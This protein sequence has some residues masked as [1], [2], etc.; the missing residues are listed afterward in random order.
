MKKIVVILLL[1]LL[2]LGAWAQYAGSETVKRAGAHLKVDG[3]TLSAEAQ[4]ALLANVGGVDYNAAWAEAVS[5]RNLGTGLTIG[6]GV[7]ALGGL[8]AV[9]VGLVADVV[10][11][12][13]GGI[14]GSI[15]G[16][17]GAQQGAQE[18]ATAGNGI[19]TGGLIATGL[20]VGALA[21]GIPKL[22][23]NNRKLNDLVG[24]CNGRPAAQVS[25]GPTG[26][27]FGLAVN[28]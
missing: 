13:A 3:A 5:G 16:Q 21:F 23:V 24:A 22:V 18:G 6:G 9:M 12:A 11:A 10:G 20:G 25:L 8:A 14:I 15:G 26:N 19:V 27:G 4:R 7:A 28:F 1:S 2:P 17:E